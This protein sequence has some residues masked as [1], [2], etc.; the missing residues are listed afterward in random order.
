MKNRI[1]W[2][3]WSPG[4]PWPENCII[5]G[6]HQEGTTQ[7]TQYVARR[8][9]GVNVLVGYAYKEGKFTSILYDKGVSYEDY[10]LLVTP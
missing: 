3:Q 7:N 4:K 8:A 5:G 1:E 10:E 2:H 9:H 6:Y